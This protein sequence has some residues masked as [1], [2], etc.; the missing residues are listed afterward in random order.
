MRQS[1][2]YAHLQ[3]IVENALDVIIRINEKGIIEWVNSAS[4]RIFGY[5]QNELVG[6]NVSV[7]V[8]DPDGI[9]HDSYISRYIK[10]KDKRVIG[11]GKDVLCRKKDGTTFPVHLSII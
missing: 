10:T 9:K 7:L 6:K 8:P 1:D 4:K 5:T 2:D 3:A 11:K